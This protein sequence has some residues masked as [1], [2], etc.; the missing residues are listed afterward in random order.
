MKITS[1]LVLTICNVLFALEMHTR[2]AESFKE[3]GRSF[4][5]LI[6]FPKIVCHV[7]VQNVMLQLWFNIYCFFLDL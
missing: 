6:V 2:F 7:N 3:D 5:I 1:F 4:Q